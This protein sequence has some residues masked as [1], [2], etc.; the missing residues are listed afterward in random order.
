MKNADVEVVVQSI[1][2][3]SGVYLCQVLTEG[4]IEVVEAAQEVP[5][6]R[7]FL[8]SLPKKHRCE[9]EK[10]LIILAL[11]HASKAHA[12]A[13]T[14]CT[15]ILSLVK[16]SDKEMVDLVLHAVGRPLMQLNVLEW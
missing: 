9:E 13:S 2:D 10:Q 6:P 16:I 15:N 11:D 1:C 5:P 8:R 4:S 14:M 12:H 7:E 3:M